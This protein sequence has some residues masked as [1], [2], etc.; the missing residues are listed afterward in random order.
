MPFQ[1]FQLHVGFF[2]AVEAHGTF[3]GADHGVHYLVAVHAA[4]V[5]QVVVQLQVV[6]QGG[7]QRGVH[8]LVEQVAV[9]FNH[10]IPTSELNRGLEA[11]VAKHPPAMIG[12]HRLKFYYAAQ[13]AVRPPTFVIFSNR[14]EAVHFSYQ[15]YLVNCFR[16]QFGFTHVPLRLL[17]KGR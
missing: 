8:G 4:E 14:P 10:R 12:G 5:V 9:Q 13:S 2:Q 16:E 3:D 7:F 15:R 11:F 1:A 6:F 17:F